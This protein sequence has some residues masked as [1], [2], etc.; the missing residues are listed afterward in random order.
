MVMEDTN[1]LGD[2][3]ELAVMVQRARE[4]A[5]LSLTDVAAAARLS[6]K[7]VT[8][9]EAGARVPSGP[10]AARLAGVLRLGAEERAMLD[11]HATRTTGRSS[12]WRND[13]APLTTP[14]RGWQAT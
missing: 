13:Q 6:V 2:L 9:V 1:A 14:L 8:E 7:Y 3:A 5:G 12:P 4:R 11:R 10:V